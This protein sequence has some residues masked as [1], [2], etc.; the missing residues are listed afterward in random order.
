MV[1]G[2]MTR[3]A[4]A[5]Q[6][7]IDLKREDDIFFGKIMLFGEYSVMLGSDAITIPLQKYQAKWMFPHAVPTGIREAQS[8]K[9]L[10]GFLDY[11]SGIGALSH[12]LDLEKFRHDLEYGLYFDSNI[13][14]EYGVGSSGALVAATYA[15]YHRTTSTQSTEL[16]HL[17]ALMENHFHGQSSGIDPLSCLIG[18]PLLFSK[19]M[20][21]IVEQLSPA[22]GFQ[23]GIFLIDTGITAKTE[24]LVN[25]FHQ[26]LTHYSHYKK[27]RDVLIAETNNCIDHLL[28]NRTDDFFNSLEKISRFQ[29]ENMQLMIPDNWKSAWENGLDSGKLYLKLCGSGGGGF[30]L[31]FARDAGAVDKN[32]QTFR[33]A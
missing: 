1:S 23:S 16:R 19:T 27:V 9:Y 31:G 11:L 7:L 30:L 24:P 2:L 22:P 20:T 3:W 12:A 29:Y 32:L 4:K 10:N 21:T 13:P 8:N 17:L 6:K 5:P 26:Q 28:N 33:L 25:H 14:F 15:R 18:K